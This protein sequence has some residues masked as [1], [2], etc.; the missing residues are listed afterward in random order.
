MNLVKDFYN[1]FD[2]KYIR[3]N[4]VNLNKIERKQTFPAY[5]AAARYTYELAKAEGFETEL[6]EF[7]AD[8]KTPLWKR[9]LCIL[10]PPRSKEIE[11]EPP[12]AILIPKMQ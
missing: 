1:G 9:R 10:P 12:L 2:R 8:G 6:I 7:P 11:K 5:E 3:E 4:L